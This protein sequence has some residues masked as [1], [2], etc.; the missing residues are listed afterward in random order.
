MTQTNL[1]IKMSGANIFEPSGEQYRHLTGMAIRTTIWN[2][3]APSAI[4]AWSLRVVTD[5]NESAECM[6][7]AMPERLDLKGSPSITLRATDSLMSKTED[8]PVGTTPVIG[9][10]LFYV[11]MAKLKI[12]QPD[13]RLMLTVTDI[14]DRRTTV[15]Q[16]VGDWFSIRTPV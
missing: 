6:A 5:T 9:Q 3:G 10:L 15:T 2:V 13:T 16:R 1:K 4:I 14:F 7:L 8:K 11:E 12:L